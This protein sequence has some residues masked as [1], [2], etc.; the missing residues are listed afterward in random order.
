[1][2]YDFKESFRFS[3]FLSEPQLGNEFQEFMPYLLMPNSI[4]TCL[5][6]LNSRICSLCKNLCLSCCPLIFIDSCSNRV[7]PC[8]YVYPK[9]S[10]LDF[11]L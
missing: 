10:S 11:T 9:F 8:H 7:K 5:G 1:M 2:K 4:H 3:L 6:F